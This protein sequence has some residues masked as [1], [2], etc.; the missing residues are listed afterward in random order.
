MKIYPYKPNGQ[1]VDILCESVSVQALE[2]EVLCQGNKHRLSLPV[3]E[4]PVLHNHT[5]QEITDE[6]TVAG[7]AGLA[8]GSA[9]SAIQCVRIKIWL[10]D[11]IVIL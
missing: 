8:G 4:E 1:P 2:I 5:D 7:L 11:G 10:K 3:G 6:E 9:E